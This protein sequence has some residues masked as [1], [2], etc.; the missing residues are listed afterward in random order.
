MDTSYFSK[1]FGTSIERFV[2]KNVL[3]DL[4]SNSFAAQSVEILSILPAV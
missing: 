1:L 4:F 3:Y 2:F